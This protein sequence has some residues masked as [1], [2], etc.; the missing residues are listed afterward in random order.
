MSAVKAAFESQSRACAKLGSPF[1]A[2]LMALAA[3]RLRPGTAVADRVLGWQGDPSAN[4]DSVPLRFAGALHALKRSGAGTLAQVYPPAEASDDS[5][6]SGVEAAMADHSAFLLDRLDLPPQTN[7]V[8]RS[9]AVT[10]ALHIVAN[11]FGLPIDLVEV[12]CSAGLNLR[13]DRFHLK[14]GDAAYGPPEAPVQLAPDWTGDA[15]PAAELRIASR[16]G[17]DLN[18]LDPAREADRL[19]SYIWPDQPD[20]IARTQ[21]AIDIAS[22]TPADLVRTDA[23]DW[24][25]QNLRPR[26]G[27]ASFLFHTIAW[28]YLPEPARLRGDAAIAAAGAMAREN[29]PLARFAMEA[30]GPYASLSLQLWPG[31]V[32][33]PLGRA[34]YH[35]RW[36]AWGD[37]ASARERSDGD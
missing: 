18:P 23:V 19:V 24:L 10:P 33:L 17:L 6:W 5:L 35:G 2:R 15:P 3:D 25:E 31:A 13:G 11:R 7:E 8:R 12:G 22:S 29:A 20:R 36:I 32:I 37:A 34:D 21:A 30:A 28:Q 16:T 9:A 14:A 26:D 27:R 4:A 1:M